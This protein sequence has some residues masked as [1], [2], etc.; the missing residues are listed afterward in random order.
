MKSTHIFFLIL[1]SILFIGCVEIEEEEG[2]EETTTTL[3]ET[4]TTVTTPAITTTTTFFTT[5]FTTIPTTTTISKLAYSCDDYCKK[6]G[7]E[8]GLCR[9]TAARCRIYGINEIH[10]PLGDRYCPKG[11]GYDAC[12]CVFSPVTTTVTTTVVEEATT[13]TI[14]LTPVDENKAHGFERIKP[15]DTTVEYQSNGL[16]SFKILNVVGVGIKI[17]N[18]SSEKCSG[19]VGLGS[20]D[21]SQLK[22]GEDTIFNAW[23]DEK[24]EGEDFKVDLKFTYKE[25]VSDMDDYEKDDG[26]ITGMVENG[27]L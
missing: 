11:T 24:T 25:L 27:K 19:G 10:K 26:V 13:V 2:G 21:E 16:L 15:I 9:R 17:L 1:L 20:L 22:A 5:I 18:V 8:M 14:L 7:F 12:C 3:E 4:T 23:C 6:E